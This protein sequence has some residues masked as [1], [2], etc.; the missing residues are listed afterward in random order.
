MFCKDKKGVALCG[1]L[2]LFCS[3][4]LLAND[5]PHQWDGILDVGLENESTV[6]IDELDS[7]ADESSSSRILR[8]NLNYQY[9]PDD[10]NE[11]LLAGNFIRKN[12]VASNEFDSTLH[13]Y[14]AS[15]SHKFEVFTLGARAQVIDSDLD[16]NSFLKINQ[17]TPYV[18]FF[19]GKQWFI[20]M[21]MGVSDKT[22]VT[23]QRR[24]AISS[25][26]SVD[27]YRF[28]Q[29]IN[30]Y[31]L[32]SY[33]SGAERA[34]DDLFSQSFNQLRVG[35]VKKLNWLDSNHKIRFNWRYLRR[36]YNDKI[37]PEIETFRVDNRRQWELEWEVKLT[38]SVY[39]IAN[40]QHNE[41]DS[42][43]DVASYDQ[44]NS[45]VALQY[46]F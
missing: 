39:L 2:T 40:Y 12:F 43:L 17:I 9:T 3:V 13:I 19:V 21:S 28:I 15:Y 16:S 44:R 31:L 1:L 18:S 45:S 30:H 20:N 27:S 24:S 26:L 36:N 11:W 46:H 6:I 7:T 33:K 34:Q 25:E 42:R 35:W 23:D 5:S 8:L 4:D 38:S 29:G 14:S 22:I 41:Q 10:K 37:N 32:F